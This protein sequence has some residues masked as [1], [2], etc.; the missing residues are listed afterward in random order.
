MSLGGRG[1]QELDKYL[2]ITRNIGTP[3]ILLGNE[4][5]YIHTTFQRVY[6]CVSVW[7]ERG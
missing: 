4:R 5:T 2:L 6:V 1:V 7:R 3:R